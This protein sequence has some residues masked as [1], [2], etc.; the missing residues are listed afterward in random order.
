MTYD[1]LDLSRPH[2]V[3]G[4]QAEAQRMAYEAKAWFRAAGVEAT[5]SLTLSPDRTHWIG[6]TAPLT[7]QQE[8]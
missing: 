7:A 8:T 5:V 4:T 6:V 1:S 3:R 2:K